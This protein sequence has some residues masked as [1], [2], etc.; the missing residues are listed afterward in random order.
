MKCPSIFATPL[1]YQKKWAE[2]IGR[3]KRET[4]FY[5]V[6]DLIKMGQKIR[7][8]VRFVYAVYVPS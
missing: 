5:F 4:V 1:P 7:S 8:V 6:I 2:K 3:V